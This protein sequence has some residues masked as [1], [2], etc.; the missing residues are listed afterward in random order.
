MKLDGVLLYYI[1][2]SVRSRDHYRTLHSL[3][4]D[5]K[6]ISNHLWALDHDDMV[7]RANTT[8]IDALIEV[9]STYND[10][11]VV[12]M[13]LLNGITWVKEQKNGLDWLGANP[14]Q[15]LEE[16]HFLQSRMGKRR[17]SVAAGED[18]RAVNGRRPDCHKN[19]VS[20]RP[21]WPPVS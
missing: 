17:N 11:C 8:D 5:Q 6:P 9:G 15:L 19:T 7:S 14:E 1:G 21:N 18:R 10:D 16:P 4:H 2:V 3:H 13:H 20:S 12:V